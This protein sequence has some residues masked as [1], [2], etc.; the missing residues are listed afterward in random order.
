MTAGELPWSVLAFRG[1][2]PTRYFVEFYWARGP[3][4]TRPGLRMVRIDRVV[5]ALPTMDGLHR[6]RVAVGS[7]RGTG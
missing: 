6:E 5:L 3:L 4:E 2:R 7:H 1:A